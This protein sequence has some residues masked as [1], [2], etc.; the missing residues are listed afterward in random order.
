[1]EDVD[2]RVPLFVRFPGPPDFRTVSPAAPKPWARNRWP[3]PV[4]L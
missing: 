3:R 1:M 4:A 2:S